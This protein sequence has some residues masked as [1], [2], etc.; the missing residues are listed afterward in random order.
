MRAA[1]GNKL[2]SHSIQIIKL[3]GYFHL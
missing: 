1:H 3:R 2:A